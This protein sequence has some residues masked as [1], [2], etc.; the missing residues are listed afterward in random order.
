MRAL[1]LSVP[2]RFATLRVRLPAP[3]VDGEAKA[4]ALQVRSGLL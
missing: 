1:E 4:M 3:V 2:G